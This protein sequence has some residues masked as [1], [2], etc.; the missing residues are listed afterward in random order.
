MENVVLDIIEYKI[1]HQPWFEKLNREWIEQHFSM[2]PIDIEV[3]Q[4][5]N[6]HI[7]EKGGSI[8]MA[9][10]NNTIAAT[11]ALKFVSPGVYEFTKMAVDEKYRGKKIGFA[12][13]HAAIKKAKEQNAHKIILYSNRILSPA[14]S[15]YKKLGFVEVPVDMLYKR[16]DIKMELT[17]KNT[18]DKM[19][20]KVASL[21]DVEVLTSL[22]ATTFFETFES[23]NT[24][25]DMEAYL[26]KNFTVDQ[27]L[28]EL[29]DERNQFF[30][31]RDGETAVGYAK[32]RKLEQPEGLDEENIIELERLYTLQSYVGKGVGKMLMETCIRFATE[33]GNKVI[34]LGVWEHNAR[35]M[36]FYEKWGFEKFGSHP[37]MVGND[38][39]T[40]LLMKKEL[41]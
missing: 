2:E 12:L 8:L 14:I 29:R 15:L 39:Q 6:V 22:G 20:V 33:N 32:M 27:L 4:Q 9:V 3:L 1:E 7:I 17:L 11:V 23:F 41:R 37:F 10:Y 18:V 28:L 34:W 30:L 16:S 25:D 26:E 38:L 21:L 24:A 35:A 5:P 36:S 40:D 19:T 31:A 13:A